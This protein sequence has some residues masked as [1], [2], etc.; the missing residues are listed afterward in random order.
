M[1]KQE[2]E[3]GAWALLQTGAPH[4]CLPAKIL[5]FVMALWLPPPLVPN[6]YRPSK[7]PLQ[8]LTAAACAPAAAKTCEAAVLGRIA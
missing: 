1:E 6:S 5:R 7:L 8:M 4:D 2:F 3:G